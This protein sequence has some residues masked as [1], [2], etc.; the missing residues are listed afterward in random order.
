MNPVLLNWDC[1]LGELVIHL[2][3]ARGEVMKEL[4]SSVLTISD[5]KNREEVLS[6]ESTSGSN[7][8]S[9]VMLLCG[10]EWF[11]TQGITAI[12]VSLILS[13]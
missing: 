3:P 13:I 2:V 6:F 1:T 12:I 11:S 10:V 7:S 5:G 9:I 4:F 8:S